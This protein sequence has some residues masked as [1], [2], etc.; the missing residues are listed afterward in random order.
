VRLVRAGRP[1]DDPLQ[2]DLALACE[3]QWKPF[4]AEVDRLNARLA[5]GARHP[6]PDGVTEVHER[7]IDLLATDLVYSPAAVQAA[8]RLDDTEWIQRSVGPHDP[9]A[10]TPAATRRYGQPQLSRLE[11]ASAVTLEDGSVRA[12]L[13]V[14]PVPG[15][16]WEQAFEAFETATYRERPDRLPLR[17]G[18]FVLRSPP[19]GFA[20]AV[21]Q[22]RA[23]VDRFVA[24]QVR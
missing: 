15:A 4:F 17:H 5:T 19:D 24:L 10:P 14:D 12:V 22:L 2:R 20:V 11:L 3:R 7:F 21:A 16:A 8:R 23:R 6:G 9:S 18:A 13:R 1:E